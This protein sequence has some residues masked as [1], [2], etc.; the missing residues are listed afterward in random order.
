MRAVV[1][2]GPTL[3]AEIARP[4][5]DAT[6]L[7]PVAQG[8]ILRVLKSQ[9]DMIGIIDGYFQSVPSVWHKEIL[10]A[11]AEGVYVAGAASI[12][13]LR[14]AEL[15][16]FGMI[17]IGD[18]FQKFHSGEYI[19]DDEVA[20]AHAPA[21]QG[22]RALSEAMV[23]IRD[24]CD[25]AA[26]TGVITSSE[27]EGLMRIAKSLHFS[28][29]HWQAILT[30]AK[31]EG[32]QAS[33]AE[34]IT[35]FR[36]QASPGAK[37]RD[38]IALLQHLAEVEENPGARPRNRI[39]VEQTAFLADLKQQVGREAGPEP[40]QAP[41][42][43]LNVARK[44]VLLGILANREAARRGLM[45]GSDDVNDMTD[46]FRGA[47]SLEDENRFVSWKAAHA[48]PEEDFI[49]AMRRFTEVVRVEEACGPEIDCELDTYL[50]VY[51]AAAQNQHETPAWV[52]L[53]LTLGRNAGG[54]QASARMLFK[55]LLPVL[56]HLRKRG[57]VKMFHF[58]R[59]SPDV[60][61]RFQAVAPEEHLLPCIGPLFAKLHA[62]GAVLSA[63]RSV[64]EPEARM[65]GGAE[66]TDA[67]HEYF[68]QDSL[69]WVA[70]DQIPPEDRT[71]SLE[72]FCTAVITDM[73]ANVLGCG[74]EIWDVWQNFRELA[75]GAKAV[76]AIQVT[77]GELLRKLSHTASPQE[78]DVL[79]RYAK[80]NRILAESLKQVWESGRLGVGI[81]S[82]LPT[83]AMF[84]CNRFGLDGIKQS[85]IAERATIAWN[86]YRDHTPAAYV[87]TGVGHVRAGSRA[88]QP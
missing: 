47:Y 68:H 30:Q 62:S 54:P 48:L 63:V 67:V 88:S 58:V 40:E 55:E 23:N 59:K 72:Q 82:L 7:P 77:G 22:Y 34:R 81:R 86:P 4:Y 65:F 28:Q 44:K 45:I 9:P 56:A 74:G 75:G 36:A 43:P 42:T 71:M 57:T 10:T 66:A 73:F 26:Q 87:K 31:A 14:A 6:F 33:V 83:I 25:A 76:G 41:G 50:R 61:L 69:Q 85:A 5:L 38:A 15:A 32:M 37:E 8:D 51:S 64:Y 80:A 20:V 3:P 2:L 53:N 46:W 24:W 60:R 18:I 84:H 29:R 17:G 1:F 78:R 21:D 49:Y 70:W 52:Q 11:L 79:K 19:D 16:H 27:A 13:A 39:Y 35:K 12:G